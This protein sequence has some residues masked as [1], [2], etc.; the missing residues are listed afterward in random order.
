MFLS[1]KTVSFGNGPLAAMSRARPGH[2]SDRS[3]AGTVSGPA[4]LAEELNPCLQ[5]AA[6]MQDHAFIA[7][8]LPVSSCEDELS[9]ELAAGL[10]KRC[11]DAGIRLAI[12]QGTQSGNSV[13]EVLCDLSR[14]A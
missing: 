1:V 7:F 14:F 8:I 5:D 11:A 9:G 3:V 10:M 6:Q 4:Y 13:A 12:L 2:T